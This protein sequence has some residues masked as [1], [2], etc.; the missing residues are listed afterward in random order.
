MQYQKHFIGHMKMI[1]AKLIVHNK[2]TQRQDTLMIELKRNLTMQN[3]IPR[4]GF[5]F[6][7]LNRCLL[8]PI[9]S[10]ADFTSSPYQI[11]FEHALEDVPPL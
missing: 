6:T 5:F 9:M 4:N 1:S 10:N 7:W 2:T 11:M 3:E 8:F